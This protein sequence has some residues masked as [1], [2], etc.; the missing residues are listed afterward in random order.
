ML[1]VRLLQLIMYMHVI[2]YLLL[3]GFCAE[4]GRCVEL[5][6]RLNV[7]DT[8]VRKSDT[9]RNRFYGIRNG[10]STTSE[11]VVTAKKGLYPTPCHGR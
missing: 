5:T 8:L 10:C 7:A 9:A 3:I 2:A 6:A 11:Y 4:L 1:C